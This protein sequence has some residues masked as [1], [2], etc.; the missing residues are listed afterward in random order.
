VAQRRERESE[1]ITFNSLI[2]IL[3][4]ACYAGGRIRDPI[5]FA[6]QLIRCGREK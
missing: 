3:F 2:S 1:D 4:N 5:S 6:A